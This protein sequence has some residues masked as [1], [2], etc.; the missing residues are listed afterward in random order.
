MDAN[1]KPN[2]L[3][4]AV[5]DL[6]PF[7]GCYGDK[8]AHTPNIDAMAKRGVTFYNAMCTAPCC[9]PSRA[10]LMTGLF[11]TKTGLYGFSGLGGV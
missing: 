10:A 7:L 3:F 9:G 11:P 4:I 5:D 1:A 8:N 6:R 2:V